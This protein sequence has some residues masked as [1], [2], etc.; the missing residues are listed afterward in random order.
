MKQCVIV[1]GSNNKICLYKILKNKIKTNKDNVRKV[2]APEDALLLGFVLEA[3]MLLWT[4][5]CVGL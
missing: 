2:S 4:P 3:E 5:R 1:I